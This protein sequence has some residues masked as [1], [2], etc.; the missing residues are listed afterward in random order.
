MSLMAGGAVLARG[1][2]GAAEAQNPPQKR[3]VLFMVADDLNTALGCYGH[4]VVQTPNL[5]KLA[6]QGVRFERAY[7]Q[8]PSCC[9][10]RTSF[11]SG[12]RPETTQ[13]F[14]NNVDPRTHLKDV[15]FLPEHFQEHGYFT[16]RVGKIAH[17]LF[18]DSITWNV[19]EDS[20]V[21]EPEDDGSDW[22]ITKN[23][24]EDEVDG[25]TA[26]RIIQLLEENKDKSFFIAAGFKKP[27]KP[28]I[29]PSKY[30][31]LYPLEKIQRPGGSADDDRDIPAIALGPQGGKSKDDAE[32]R[33]RIAAYYACV[34]LVDAQVGVILDSL[35]QLQLRENTLIVFLSDHGH[36]LGEH[37]GLWAKGTLFEESARVPLIVAVPGK[38]AGVVSTRLVELVDLYPTLAELCGLPAPRGVEGT[39]FVPLLEDPRRPWKKAAF[40]TVRRERRQG[41]VMGQSVRTERYCYN[42]WGDEK[43]AELYDHQNDPHEYTNLVNVPEHAEQAA[44]MRN[45][46]REG[47]RGALPPKT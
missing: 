16:A 14:E 37:G 6:Q 47:W 31:D 38:K 46:L 22:G 9:P 13:V 2:F 29:A 25:S 27:H 30:F 1:V 17:T 15:T 43:T 8:F 24:D 34:S 39:S 23:K 45:L 21:P 26:R 19:S 18:P 4:P 20:P 10:S 3:N 44:R 41:I 42:E 40:T 5:D 7:C 28:W 33:Q 32:I 35:E 11:L 36:H 12:R